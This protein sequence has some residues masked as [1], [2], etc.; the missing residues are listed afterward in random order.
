MKTVV[1]IIVGSL[2]G[3]LGSRYWLVGSGLSLVPWAIVGLALGSWSDRRTAMINGAAYGFALSFVFLIA[4]YTGTASLVSRLPFFA[5]LG[6]F[7]ALCGLVLGILG[8]LLKV[9][10]RKLRIKAA[11]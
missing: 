8:F 2:L 9:G 11:A 10:V 1:S 7:G 6:L 4:G 3:I 5:L